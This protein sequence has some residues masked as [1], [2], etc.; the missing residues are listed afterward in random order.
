[1]Y[2]CNARVIFINNVYCFEKCWGGG[3][4]KILGLPL[5]AGILRVSITNRHILKDQEKLSLFLIVIIIISSIHTHTH[6][7]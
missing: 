7:L 2:T 4:I 1:M 5:A 6:P 3:M